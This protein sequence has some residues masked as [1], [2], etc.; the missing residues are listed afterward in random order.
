MNKENTF[1]FQD[2][3]QTDGD[4]LRLVKEGK[5]VFITRYDKP[6][7]VVIP[8]EMFNKLK[9]NWDEKINENYD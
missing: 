5:T 6:V 7:M 2:L 8:Y 4:I 1:S 9:K 3:R